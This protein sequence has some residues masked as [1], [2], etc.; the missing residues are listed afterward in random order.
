MGINA[1]F[2]ESI[3]SYHNFCDIASVFARSNSSCTSHAI[4]S[5][6][7]SNYLVHDHNTA[8]IFS[9]W[10]VTVLRDTFVFP[11][12]VECWKTWQ[13][14]SSYCNACKLKK[15]VQTR[16]GLSWYTSW[17]EK[18]CTVSCHYSNVIMSAIASQVTGVS[19]SF[20]TAF[21][22]RRRSKKTSKLRVIVLCEGNSPV[23]CFNLMTSPSGECQE[24]IETMIPWLFAALG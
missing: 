23:K 21:L 8:G 19:I 11:F 3:S 17:S 15:L 9:L 6:I 1:P 22:F 12:D 14:F 10:I 24:T 20:S 5:D 7:F 2:T 18:V 13:I 4:L 16:H